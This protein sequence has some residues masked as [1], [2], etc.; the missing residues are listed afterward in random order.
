MPFTDYKLVKS[1]TNLT[2]IYK[3]IQ[4]KINNTI[5]LIQKFY[6]RKSST[7]IYSTKIRVKLLFVF[8]IFYIFKHL[9]RIQAVQGPIIDYSCLNMQPEI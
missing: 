4:N 6:E 5:G 9:Y 8:Y 2:K 7:L 1:K 3:A